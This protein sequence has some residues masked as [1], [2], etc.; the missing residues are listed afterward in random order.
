MQ[1][2]NTFKRFIDDEPRLLVD[3]IP[4]AK[5]ET[6]DQQRAFLEELITQ[7]ISTIIINDPNSNLHQEIGLRCFNQSAEFT[8]KY[9]TI[10]SEPDSK[11]STKLGSENT[12]SKISYNLTPDGKSAN[13]D[14]YY[15]TLTKDHT[16]RRIDILNIKTTDISALSS[17]DNI[18]RI[19]DF[20]VENLSNQSILAENEAQIP[21]SILIAIKL[22]KNVE[23]KLK[24][25]LAVAN[26]Q[27]MIEAEFQTQIQSKPTKE[28]L[29]SLPIKLASQLCVKYVKNM[30]AQKKEKPHMGP[31]PPLRVNNE[32]PPPPS[33]KK[34]LTSPPW[35][36]TATTQLSSRR[37]SIGAKSG[38]TATDLNNNNSSS[39][40]SSS[41]QPSLSTNSNTTWSQTQSPSQEKHIWELVNLEKITSEIKRKSAQEVIAALKELT[42]ASSESDR[43]RFA[44]KLIAKFKV[45]NTHFPTHL[46][47]NRKAREL[48]NT[49]IEKYHQFDPSP[50][51]QAPPDQKISD[52]TYV[53][54][55]KDAEQAL[56]TVFGYNYYK[57]SMKSIDERISDFYKQD[58]LDSKKLVYAKHVFTLLTSVSEFVFATTEITNFSKRYQEIT[59]HI[60]SLLQIHPNLNSKTETPCEL[61][62]EEIQPFNLLMEDAKGLLPDSNRDNISQTTM[63]IN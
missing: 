63:K 25:N 35:K 43:L 30:P 40:S 58:T 53:S 13:T 50:S 7:N 2:L 61:T 14:S 37:L 41:I 1:T 55:R 15:L 54:I 51:N 27:A 47:E 49:F 60:K 44:R 36:K 28:Q 38:C 6:T 26:I 22:F 45:F 42:D 32:I 17:P 62:V 11:A 52:E 3:Q 20:L 46:T 23:N 24:S 19:A 34:T 59:N 56:L 18:G 31:L 29:A 48:L 21:A 5:K 10:S 9:T 8:E 39:S 16:T 57:K 4:E 12:I 33:P